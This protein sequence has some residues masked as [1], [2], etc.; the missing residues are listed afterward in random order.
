MY[1]MEM[2]A[3]QI[4]FNGKKETALFENRHVIFP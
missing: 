2:F 3:V 4:L 1:G